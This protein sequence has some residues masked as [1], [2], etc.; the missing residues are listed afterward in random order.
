[1]TLGYGQG[2]QGKVAVDVSD[3]FGS[4]DAIGVRFNAAYQDGDSA[5]DDESSTLGLAALGLDYRADQYRLSA[6]LGWQDNKLKETR[7]SVNLGGVSSVPKAPDG[8]KKIGRNLGPTPMKRMSLVPFEE[9]MILLITL[10]LM[11]LTVCEV[12]RKKTH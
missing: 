1:M 2:D 9:N 3:R 4:D 6:D 11:V 12:A 8:S 5:I 10:P 7:P